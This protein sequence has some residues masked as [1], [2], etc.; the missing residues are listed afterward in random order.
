M[1]EHICPQREMLESERLS[2]PHFADGLPVLNL[3]RLL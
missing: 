1:L 3:S 2:A